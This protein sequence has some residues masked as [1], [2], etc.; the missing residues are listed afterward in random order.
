MFKHRGLPK[1]AH[2]I[3]EQAESSSMAHLW[4]SQLL[5]WRRVHVFLEVSVNVEQRLMRLEG[6]SDAEPLG[7]FG[8][9]ESQAGIEAACGQ[10]SFVQVVPEVSV[11]A[12]HPAGRALS[13]NPGSI[14]LESTFLIAQLQPL[15]H[16]KTSAACS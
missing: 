15:S 5:Q 7:C 2:W 12:Y 9:V 10:H 4:G 3:A 1:G 16:T 14:L 6:L 13:S 11:L 8:F